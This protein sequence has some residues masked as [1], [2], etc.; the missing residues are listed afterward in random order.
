MVHVLVVQDSGAKAHPQVARKALEI[1]RPDTEVHAPAV[2]VVLPPVVV[3][4]VV[5]AVAEADSVVLRPAR[6]RKRYEQ[7][8]IYPMPPQKKSKRN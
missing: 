1:L 2:P 4:A 3:E 5:G 6:K 7:H 8:L